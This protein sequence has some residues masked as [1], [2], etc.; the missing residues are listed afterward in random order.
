MEK[1]ME[2]AMCFCEP[3]RKRG[4]VVVKMHKMPRKSQESFTRSPWLV[5]KRA[6]NSL[7]L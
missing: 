2:V 4:E 5:T 6:M 7:T 1:N 3:S